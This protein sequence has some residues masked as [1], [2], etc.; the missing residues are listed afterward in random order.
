MLASL[1]A[2]RATPPLHE[3][4]RLGRAA[5]LRVAEMERMS[6]YTRP[7]IYAAMRA[8]DEGAVP[9]VSDPTLLSR[10]VLVVLC[11]VSGAIPVGE[12]ADRLR[13]EIGPIRAGLLSLRA[14]GMCQIEG[15]LGAE[16]SAMSAVATDF[17]RDMLRTIFDDLF[18]RRPDAFSVYVR[19]DADERAAIES[20]ARDVV[21]AH[22]HTVIEASVAPSR[23]TTAEFAFAV[24][25]PS[26]R[27][28]LAIVH[29]VWS[30]VRERAGLRPAAAW[31]T[32]L[33]SPAPL[34][35]SESP[36]LDAF[37]E[38]ICEQMPQVAV[39]VMQARRR[40][41]GDLDERML[42][43]RCV[44]A[45]ATALRRAVG[46]KNDP[47]PITNGD[48]AFGELAPA[49]TV[50]VASPQAPIKRA[51][52][53]ALELAADH[54]G[55]LRGGELGSVRAPGQPPRIVEEVRPTSKELAL[56]SREAGLAVGLAGKQDIVDV[57]K[58][59]LEVVSPRL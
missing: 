28:A 38:A 40:Y 1:K 6:G 31:I 36:V 11:S 10:Q 20:A 42:A 17:G 43:G 37:A 52:R 44:T 57:A 49:A 41:S 33:I 39:E 56:M 45:A 15:D 2:D 47:R 48:E 19:L 35:S 9:A 24:H 12:I 5:G 54:L 55:P 4:V 29:D 26:S 30:A 58:G 21:S 7:T 27:T 23:M 46:S 3:A 59:M 14:Q 22:E 50:P 32:D 13:L 8:L 18:L 34:P 53:R 25:A 16:P 51:T